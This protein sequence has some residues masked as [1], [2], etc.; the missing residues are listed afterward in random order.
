[1]SADPRTQ[2]R[3]AA[4]AQAA[5]P[6]PNA[7]ELAALAIERANRQ[8]EASVFTNGLEG[9]TPEGKGDWLADA[10]AKGGA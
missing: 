9:T 2:L 8:V 6:T 5:E 7:G 4:P 10:I 3:D 1:M